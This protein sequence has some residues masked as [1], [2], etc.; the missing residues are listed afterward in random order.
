MI[1]DRISYES[2]FESFLSNIIWFNIDNNSSVKRFELAIDSFI[3]KISKPISFE[4]TRT[5]FYHLHPVRIGCS[6]F[7]RQRLVAS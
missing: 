6:F 2:V 5:F 3:S 1:G 7:V 4:S